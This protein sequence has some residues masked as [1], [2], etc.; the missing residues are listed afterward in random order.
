ME[1]YTAELTGVACGA[2]MQLFSRN[3]SMKAQ[4]CL[5]WQS[6]DVN[7]IT[8]NSANKQVHEGHATS[9]SF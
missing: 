3:L 9:G 5:N 4:D 8:K 7:L 1:P 6:W 2:Q